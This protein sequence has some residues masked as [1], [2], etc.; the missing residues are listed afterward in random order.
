MSWGAR[1]KLLPALQYDDVSMAERSE[2]GLSIVDEVIELEQKYLIP[3]YKR[4]PVVLRR[5]RGVYVYDVNG[6]RYL[7]LISGI[8]V[9]ALG[10][11]HPRI[12]KVLKEQA[13]QLIHCSNL[14]YH[15]YQGQLARRLAEISGLDRCFFCNSGAE[16]TEAALKLVRLYG[17]RQSPDKLE[18]ISLENSF[19][20]RT[21]GAISITGQDKYRAPFEP[22]LSHVRFVPPGDIQALENAVNRNTAGIFVEG[23]QGEGGVRMVDGAFLRRARELADEVDALLVFDEVQCGLGRTGKY[24]SYQ[25]H[26]PPIEPDVVV[27]AKPLGCGLPIGAVMAK[28]KVAGVMEPGRH[29]S[30]F[31]GGPLV[32]RVALEFLSILDELLPSIYQMGGYFRMRLE[33]L[34]LHYRFIQDIRCY[35][36]MMG[37]EL[38]IPG[39]PLVDEALQHGLLINCT[40]E[41]VLRFLPPYVITEPEIDQA[42]QLLDKV[43]K[44]G[45]ELYIQMGLAD[46]LIRDERQG[47]EARVN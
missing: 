6:K 36:L 24:F 32:C 41:R 47:A 17:K 28:E 4:S 31:G 15:E 43:F 1:S 23:I 18:I 10:Y 14:F 5:G 37:V 35:G 9:N 27:V 45:R 25:L 34:R 40:Q 20:G 2:S 46:E 22:L 21:T 39:A 8:G 3:T 13:G 26:E 11:N 44:K 16:A 7:D 30:T 38:K 12:L 33:E 19:H 42:I 29:G